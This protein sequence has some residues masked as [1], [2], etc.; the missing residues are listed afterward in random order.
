MMTMKKKKS[1]LKRR[2][3]R[4]ER[5][6]EKQCIYYRHDW[7]SIWYKSSILTLTVFIEEISICK[8]KC[9]LRRRLSSIIITNLFKGLQNDLTKNE[10]YF[11]LS[12]FFIL[13]KTNPFHSFREKTRSLLVNVF[14]TRRS[15]VA[16]GSNE[17]RQTIFIFLFLYSLY[18]RT[19]LVNNLVSQLLI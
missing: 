18:R 6:R 16:L 7:F 5:E 14:R 3:N 17:V 10:F 12:F 9:I 2:K 11:S 1:I 8:I 15:N 4:R 13:K 19:W